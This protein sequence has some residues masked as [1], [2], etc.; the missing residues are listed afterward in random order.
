MA[1]KTDELEVVELA[2]LKVVNMAVSKVSGWV[3]WM[4]KVLVGS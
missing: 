3:E 2:L 1:A 4:V